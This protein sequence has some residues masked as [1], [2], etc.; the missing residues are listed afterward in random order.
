MAP[1]T[2]PTVEQQITLTNEDLVVKLKRILKSHPEFKHE[3]A[4]IEIYEPPELKGEHMA[5]VTVY[6]KVKFQDKGV[7]DRNIFIKKF[8]GN[9]LHNE[10]I[11]MMK[12]MEKEASFFNEYL[13]Y[14][15]KFCKNNEGTENLLDFFPDHLYADDDIVVLD[16]LVL[17]DT[18]V[19]LPK[20][21]KQD[22]ETA[23]IVL[24]HLA[25]F[26]AVSNAIVREVGADEFRAK[27]ELNCTE[28]FD[29]EKNPMMQSMFDSS[30]GTCLTILNKYQLEGKTETV[31]YLS[32]LIGHIYPE[33]NE[34][35]KSNHRASGFVAL[36]HGDCWNNNMLFKL[37]PVTKKVTKHIFVDFQITRFGSPSID[38]GYFLF[39]S[40][41]S[42]VRRAHIKELLQHYY[43]EFCK[44]LDLF[45]KNMELTF[46]DFFED[47]KKNSRLGFI[48][49]LT[50]LSAIGAFKDMDHDSMGTDPEKAM[51]MFT[52][53][54]NNWI[55]KNPDK[56]E[57]I[58]KELIAVVEEEKK[59]IGI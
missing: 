46:E 21:D 34:L 48:F 42:E 22:L 36:N 16:N 30:I 54:I 38:L 33:V 2:E 18:F 31:G 6:G 59:L 1:T 56:T 24:E 3:I 52:N 10:F 15:Q 44:A 57:P 19:M 11:K 58:A 5:T 28:C 20:E 32:S 7:K 9:P 14:L 40:V 29:G 8:S 53:I 35:L 25:K 50:M 37:D 45:G 41:K 43:Y 47:Y 27:W 4:D 17:D 51:E 39:T 49:N 23:K 13:P 26:H 55:E 12:V